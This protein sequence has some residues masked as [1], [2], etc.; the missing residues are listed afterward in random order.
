MNAIEFTS[1]EV[2]SSVV[3]LSSLLTKRCWD[4]AFEELDLQLVV[5]LEEE[6]EVEVEDDDDEGSV[7]SSYAYKSIYFTLPENHCTGIPN[8]EEV[9][10][11]KEIYKTQLTFWTRFVGG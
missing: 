6:E 5:D 9:Q 4:D 8:A 11:W 1:P 10:Q 3:V 7:D 2:L